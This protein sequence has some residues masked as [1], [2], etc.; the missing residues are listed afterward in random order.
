MK[1]A[2]MK[3]DKEIIEVFWTDAVIY[4]ANSVIPKELPRVHTI[5][6]QIEKT[7]D[8]L[9]LK[10]TKSDLTSRKKILPKDKAKF[11]FIPVGMIEKTSTYNLCIKIQE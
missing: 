4:K 1:L 8:Y 3:K 6:E 2:N 7:E 11:Y 9:L 5:G 10:N